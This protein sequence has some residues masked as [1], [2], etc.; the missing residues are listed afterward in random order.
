[1]PTAQRKS[2][3]VPQP[4][5]QKNPQ[6][7]RCHC[8]EFEYETPTEFARHL[9]S[10]PPCDESTKH[11][12]L[13]SRQVLR[14]VCEK[15]VAIGPSLTRHRNKCDEY[16]ARA[17]D[18]PAPDIA[19]PF[20]DGP[21]CHIPDCAPDCVGGHPIDEG[22]NLPSK[23]GSSQNQFTSSYFLSKV[24]PP[25]LLSAS[26]S[27]AAAP[28][29][30]LSLSPSLS[31]PPLALP[32]AAGLQSVPGSISQPP[33]V[34][35]EASQPNAIPPLAADEQPLL[36]SI[37]ASL[38]VQPSYPVS[39]VS[40]PQHVAQQ[41]AQPPPWAEEQ[42]ESDPVSQPPSPPEHPPFDQGPHHA[43]VAVALQPLAPV[44][45]AVAQPPVED[46]PHPP[47]HQA[48]APVEDPPHAPFDQA[49][50]QPPPVE[51]PAQHHQ[52][53]AA[54]QQHPP[55]PAQIPAAAPPPNQPPASIHPSHLPFNIAQH[56][57]LLRYIPKSLGEKWRELCAPAFREYAF[58]SSS[59]SG[60]SKL[61]ALHKILMIPALTLVTP[62]GGKKR[63]KRSLNARFASFSSLFKQQQQ[64]AFGDGMEG[65]EA[66]EAALGMHQHQAVV[67]AP[68]HVIHAK[69]LHKAAAMARQGFLGRAAKSLYSEAP[70]DLTDPTRFHQ[71]Q[72]LHPQPAGF[73]KPGLP[74]SPDQITI[75]PEDKSFARFIRKHARGAA[76]GPSGWTA[77]MVRDLFGNQD[78]V[79]GLAALLGDIANG[80]L[81]DDCRKVL[82][83][84]RL[85]CLPKGPDNVRPIAISEIFHRLATSYSL[86][87]LW[88]SVH[89]EQILGKVQLGVGIPGGTEKVVI[90]TQSLLED[91][92]KQLAALT[93]DFRNAFNERSR[94]DILRAVF[95]NERLRPI[96]KL[97]DWTYSTESPLWVYDNTGR[98]IN[99]IFSRE[100]VRQGD[101]LG[102]L[103]YALSMRTIFDEAAQ[104]LAP[105]GAAF[106]ILDDLTLIGKPDQL[107]NSLDILEQRVPQGSIQFRK[108]GLIYFHQQQQ[109]LSQPLIDRLQQLN[110]PIHDQIATLL[111]APISIS[112][113]LVKEELKNNINK[114]KKMFQALRDPRLPTQIA[115]LLLRVCG[116]PRMNYLCRTVRPEWLE[117][118]AKAFDT[119][120]INTAQSRLS[121]QSPELL[122]A[123][124]SLTTPIRLGGFGL[125]STAAVSPIAYLSAYIQAA[126]VLGSLYP[127][128]DPPLP[129]S[130]PPNHPLSLSVQSALDYSISECIEEK[131]PS[132]LQPFLHK[133][134]NPAALARDVDPLAL[135]TTQQV[136]TELMH[137]KSFNARFA[138]IASLPVEQRL[139]LKS[140]LRAVT[141]R[142]SG[143]WLVTIPT[144]PELTLS[145]DEFAISSRLRLSLNPRSQPLPP[146]CH[147]CHSGIGNDQWH[148]LS[149]SL[150]K[151]QLTSNRHDPIVQIVAGWIRRTGAAVR[152][153]PR[154][155]TSDNKRPDLLIHAGTEVVW[156]DVTIRHSTAPSRA[157][158][159]ASSSLAVAKQA[160]AEK[161]HKYTAEAQASGAVFN[162]FAIETHGGWGPKAIQLAAKISGWAVAGEAAGS[163]WSAAEIR[164]N[165]RESVAIAVQRGNAR[166]VLNAMQKA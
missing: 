56:T 68:E 137:E 30:A 26:Q 57:Q 82:I 71:A 53:E 69:L 62:R 152:V 117:E 158:L 84:G 13:K 94:E 6:T 88:A 164:R 81:N 8:C 133:M 122:E 146:S 1:M 112:A 134:F 87:C 11:I 160:E 12:D 77:E 33:P 28:A 156:S 103:L 41:V 109:P 98:V 20:S 21:K 64:E 39:L 61:L 163:P 72:A 23:H 144:S 162:P 153:E 92:T 138:A 27:L 113:P 107:L 126:D 148:F 70:V 66:V 114:H 142:L 60:I 120:V 91:T 125:T 65:K 123:K 128:A 43:P 37:S 108:C 165:L 141:A 46:P 143:T 29:V 22:P 51:D 63:S 45:Q 161:I 159:G 24:V 14:C 101:P 115:F 118:A 25:Q 49:V 95:G 15:I 147:L 2:T 47:V 50:A 136:L 19:L 78:C 96:W 40:L 145:D 131:V 157:A 105:H 130:F 3:R 166:A 17:K 151:P 139:R 58:A 154:D 100:G 155:L 104:P 119:E 127:P 129:S 83:P 42:P 73:N 44:D 85:I 32:A 106:A 132:P 76:P 16:K 74:P 18:K 55:A 75:D 7:V 36:L 124:S 149:C 59:G 150:T 5:Q 116:V 10:N 97:V 79:K 111:G 135:N 140:H 86:D 34:A 38:S 67:Q 102:S 110:I 35:A 31:Q 99:R 4:K 48:V 80:R 93:I 9:N 89:P 121:L 54:P 52:P 90:A